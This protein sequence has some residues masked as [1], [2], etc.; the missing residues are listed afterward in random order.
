MRLCPSIWKRRVLPCYVNCIPFLSVR[1]I[2][3]TAEHSGNETF[4]ANCARASEIAAELVTEII[5][6]LR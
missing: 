4:H 6:E 2:T 1:C 3:D 5:K